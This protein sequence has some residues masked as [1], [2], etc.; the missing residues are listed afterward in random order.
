MPDI[1]KIGMT[2]RTPEIR[3]NEANSHDTWRPPTPYEIVL[4][5]KVLNPKKK[6]TTLHTMLSIH[7]QRISPKHEFFRV[8]PEKVKMFF[9][10][11]DGDLWVK[12]SECAP[13]QKPNKLQLH[14][15]QE[16]LELERLFQEQKQVAIDMFLKHHQDDDII[17][18]KT[19]ST[20][21]LEKHLST[22]ST[23]IVVTQYAI[24]K[25]WLKLIPIANEWIERKLKK[26][27]KK[28]PQELNPEFQQL[29]G[30]SITTLNTYK[31][32][33]PEFI[34][35][36]PRMIYTDFTVGEIVRNHTNWKLFLEDKI[37]P[38]RNFWATPFNAEIMF[39]MRFTEVK[40][41]RELALRKRLQEEYKRKW[42]LMESMA[43]LRT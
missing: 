39:S 25:M 34:S 9:D 2:E 42:D 8:S 28:T 6:E 30:H 36:F 20:E 16:T 13:T 17:D 10:L 31:D 40:E 12:T 21:E 23:S 32:I 33:I 41:A 37:N 26:F 7:T 4:A 38:D 14:L 18:V 27:P 35:S 24:K 15:H 5:K 3:L 19:L 11:I 1:L 43:S 29:T 22:V